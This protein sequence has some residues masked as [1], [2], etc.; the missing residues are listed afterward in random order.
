MFAELNTLHG[1]TVIIKVLPE[2]DNGQLPQVIFLMLNVCGTKYPHVKIIAI[3]TGSVPVATFFL[4]YV[5]TL[6]VCKDLWPAF[7]QIMFLRY[8]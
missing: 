5:E 7:S 2:E 3:I 8:C 1:K 4:N 6:H